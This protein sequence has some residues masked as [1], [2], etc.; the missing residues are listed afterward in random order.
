MQVC[1]HHGLPMP[2]KSLF[3]TQQLVEFLYK[4]VSFLLVSLSKIFAGYISENVSI[5]NSSTEMNFD[6]YLHCSLLHL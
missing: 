3:R 6:V 5:W 2:K 1:E 4:P